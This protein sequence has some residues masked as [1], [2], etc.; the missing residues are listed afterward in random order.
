VRAG[1]AD[2]IR[3]SGDAGL[4]GMIEAVI[5]VPSRCRGDEMKGSGGRH[6]LSRQESDP[7]PPGLVK[8]SDI[9]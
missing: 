8:D 9:Y 1:W 7:V 2:A 6:S 5:G 3:S 4:G